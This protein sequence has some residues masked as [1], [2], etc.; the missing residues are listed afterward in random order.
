VVG[1]LVITKVLDVV[2]EMGFTKVIE[3]VSFVVVEVVVT[4]ST[5]TRSTARSTRRT[6]RSTGRPKQKIR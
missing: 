6:E 1:F 3:M 4:T 5:T 2:V